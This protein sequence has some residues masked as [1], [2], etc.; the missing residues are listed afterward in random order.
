MST[1]GG[2]TGGG[3]ATSSFGDVHAG[4]ITTWP[5]TGG[6]EPIGKLQSN[7]GATVAG[8]FAG[9]I[10]LGGKVI[11][12]P[13][14][15]L[16]GYVVSLDSAGGIVWSTLLECTD[17]VHVTTVDV[18]DNGNVLVGGTFKGDL[19]IKG[20]TKTSTPYYEGFVALLDSFGALKWIRSVGDGAVG[21]G[22][23]VTTAAFAPDGNVVI[24]GDFETALDFDGTMLQP[25]GNGDFY[26]AKIASAGLP[27]LWSHAYGGTDVEILFSASVDPSGDVLLS[28]VYSGDAMFDSV[29][30]PPAPA[31]GYGFLAKVSGAD[32]T[33]TFAREVG[34]A[35]GYVAASPDGAYF[36]GTL[37]GDADFGGGTVTTTGDQPVVA[38]YDT[39]GDYRWSHVY[40]DAATNAGSIAYPSAT[41]SG[42]AA[43][44]AVTGTFDFGDGKGPV[45][46]T[47]GADISLAAFPPD[48]GPPRRLRFG[49]TGI[50][51]PNTVSVQASG[52][53]LVVGT[54]TGTFDVGPVDSGVS[55]ITAVGPHDAYVL[56][57]APN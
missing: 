52:A 40:G 14:A 35:L 32:G 39:T 1:G 48:S 18:N 28:G 38:A 56:F 8:S 44:W 13:A 9:T 43:A 47:G 36:T 20:V 15:T 4:W 5:A 42:L 49:S 12:A 37:K 11:T 41:A 46:V 17:T 53:A 23:D 3:T 31:D 19:T 50:Q 6:D 57:L 33:A 10:T 45:D 54:Y 55:K 30:L 26:V 25:I 16:E 24:A 2:G 21:Q 29:T 34:S 22:A 27:V 51:I 7:G